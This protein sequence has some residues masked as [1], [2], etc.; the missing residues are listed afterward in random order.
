MPRILAISSQVAHGNVGLSIIVPALQAMGHEVMAL[1]TVLLSNH[2]GHAHVAGTKIEPAVLHQMLD[3]LEANRWLAGVDGLLTGYL[4]T[5]EHVTFALEAVRRVRAVRGR[6]TVTYLCDPVLGDDPKG[7]YIDEMA[8]RAIRDNLI[9]LADIATPNRFELSFLN[10]A[11]TPLDIK[12]ANDAL[13]HHLNCTTTIATSIPSAVADETLNTVYSCG[14][15]A[16]TRVRIRPNS[17]HGT[18]D[19]FAALLL[20]AFLDTSDVFDALGRATAGVDQVLAA[21]AGCDQ[22]AVSGLPRRSEAHLTWPVA[23][24]LPGTNGCVVLQPMPPKT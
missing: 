6:H 18:G 22:L 5:R 9:A 21:S 20:S 4:P 2:P 14:V 16:L 3:A 10:S 23:F 13:A 12:S 19:L 8:A 24:T 1:P 11:A 7:L 17:P 15:A